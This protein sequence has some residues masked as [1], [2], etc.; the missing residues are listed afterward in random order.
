MWRRRPG[1]VYDRFGQAGQCA[2]EVGEDI[3]KNK[4]EDRSAL[5]QNVVDE[6]LRDWDSLVRVSP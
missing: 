5:P 6:I 3:T 4:N 2:G 1:V